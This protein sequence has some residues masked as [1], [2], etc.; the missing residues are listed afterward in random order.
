MPLE[1]GIGDCVALVITRPDSEERKTGR[2]YVLLRLNDPN[3][4]QLS[5]IKVPWPDGEPDPCEV[6]YRESDECVRLTNNA[7]FA[8]IPLRVSRLREVVANRRQRS[9]PKRFSSFSSTP[10]PVEES[11]QKKLHSALKDFVKEPLEN[12]KWKH[13]LKYLSAK[14]ANADGFLTKDEQTV[15]LHFLP[16]QSFSSKELKNICEVLR[17]TNVFGL[18]CLA[19]FYELCLSLDQMALVRSAIESSDS[20]SEQCLAVLL[21][22]VARCCRTK[23]NYPECFD[24]HAEMYE[25]ALSL[26]TV[27]TD[28][29]GSRL[30]WENDLHHV[31][32]EAL[33]FSERLS[34]IVSLFNQIEV[35]Q[36]YSERKREEEESQAQYR[37]E[38]ISLPR[39]P[40]NW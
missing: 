27:L 23:D 28:V 17:R 7:T 18:S 19:S 15:I 3:G 10:C 30:V 4:E 31:A 22:F 1:C 34:E 6:Q 38:K 40:L 36:K 26:M 35:Q 8:D 13:A 5:E 9:P 29:F 37:I 21:N 14:N 2:N 25:L 11:N 12:G 24:T 33:E 20:L 16:T 32:E 39:R